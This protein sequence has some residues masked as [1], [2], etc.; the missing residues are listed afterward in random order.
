ML[1]S[2]IP[3]WFKSTM[4]LNFDN[5]PNASSNGK[6]IGVTPRLDT[7]SW[8]DSKAKGITHAYSASGIP[9]ADKYE[10]HIHNSGATTLTT[11]TNTYAAG[12]G[13]AS[14]FTPNS[15]LIT[16]LLE[17]GGMNFNDREQ[18]LPYFFKG[19]IDVYGIGFGD[20]VFGDYTKEASHMG[21]EGFRI[22]FGNSH[23]PLYSYFVNSLNS[24][25]N[26]KLE[27]NQNNQQTRDFYFFSDASGLRMSD[28][29]NLLVGGFIGMEI[30]D[31]SGYASYYTFY[32]IQ[33]K[34]AAGVKDILISQS[35]WTETPNG[36]TECPASNSG[37]RIDRKDIQEV[38]F[39]SS[40]QH[41]IQPIDTTI[42][43]AIL[44]LFLGKGIVSFDASREA[45]SKNPA[46]LKAPNP[47][48]PT[49]W[50]S[51]PSVSAPSYATTGSP[52]P[53][54]PQSPQDL[55]LVVLNWYNQCRPILSA[56]GQL[57]YFD[58]TSS[59]NGSVNVNTI[60]TSDKRLFTSTVKPWGQ[61]TILH[62]ANDK[63]G[64][65]WGAVFGGSYF[66][67]YYNPFLSPLQ[68]ETITPIINGVSQSSKVVRGKT[69]VIE[70]V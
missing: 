40:E 42:W 37:W 33:R 1:I 18:L 22:D 4:H 32:D 13:T 30:G 61:D 12:M 63:K 62:R 11:T 48:F 64:L 2:T 21:G 5:S 34:F 29:M 28:F 65:M 24:Q 3:S 17:N 35:P 9:N 8:G 55:F 45:Y 47:L 56:G 58:Y 16:Q 50:H 68:S 52:Y 20:N 41:H 66:Y 49:T 23:Q 54:F 43:L 25:S 31:E 46:Q 53:E 59:V 69:I 19:F 7:I 39:W 26:A 51:D 57:Q 10:I 38:A 44:G 36:Y 60:N 14:Q 27:F 15:V 67:V 70:K 6:I